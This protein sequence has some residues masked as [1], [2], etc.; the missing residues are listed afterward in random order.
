MNRTVQFIIGLIAILLAVGAGVYGRNAYLREVSTYQVPV[1]VAEIP[2]YTVLSESMFQMRDMPRTLESL[3]YFQTLEALKGKISNSPLPAGL[4]VPNSS[5]VAAE[6]FRLAAAAFEVVSIPVDPVSAVG[7]QIQVGQRVN[8]YR[9]ISEEADTSQSAT[10]TQT[11]AKSIRVE[12]IAGNV[13]VVDVRTS[14]GVKAG[15]DSGD[16]Q[17]SNGSMTSGNQQTEQVQILTLALEPEAVSKVL[18]AVATS[19]KQGGLLWTTLAVP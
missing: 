2:T 3:P 15:P 9:M 4:P 19:K 16:G 1:P 5:A 14:Q 6:Q 18:D 17:S 13:L 12:R 8:L 11:P 10:G 7:G